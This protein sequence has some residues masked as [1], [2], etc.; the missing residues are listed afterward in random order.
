MVSAY[1]SPCG[2]W[3]SFAGATAER[4]GRGPGGTKGKAR[5]LAR[6]SIVAINF[7]EFDF[8]GQTR[9]RKLHLGIRMEAHNVLR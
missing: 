5:G 6:P 9:A 2:P 3:S 8:C 1:P 7:G 4:E